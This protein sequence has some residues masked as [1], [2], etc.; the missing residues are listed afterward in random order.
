MNIREYLRGQRLVTDGAMGTYYASLCGKETLVSEW[1]NLTNPELIRQ[2]HREYLEAGATL[3]RTNTFAANQRMLGIGADEQKEMLRAACRIAKEAVAA[4]EEETGKHC[5][6]AGD[7]GPLRVLA[8][9]S[10]AEE[11][12]VEYRSMV[13]CFLEEGVD[14][15]LFETFSD[16]E[17]L[18]ELTEEIRRKNAEVFCMA[19]FSLNQSGYS[20]GGKSAMRLLGQAVKMPGLDAVGFNC[21]VGSGH[22]LRLLQG[23]RLPKE[24]YFCVSPNAGYP[25]QLQNRMVFLKN[26]AYFRENMQQIAGAGVAILGACCGSTPAYIKEL[27]ELVKDL[28]PIELAAEQQRLEGLENGGQ[29]QG[30][31]GRM[32]EQ[33]EMLTAEPSICYEN[34]D[35]FAKLSAGKKVIA[36]ELDPPYDAKDEKLL[37]C[38]KR[39]QELE[40]DLLTVADSPQGRSRMDSI[41]TA[42]KLTHATGL[43]VMPHLS[44]RDRNVIAI[45]SALL[46]AYAND[47]RNVLF[48]TGDPVPGEARGNTTAVFDYNSVNLMNFAQEL[49]R[50]HFAE[51]PFVYGGAI[52]QGRRNFEIE[53]GR[54]KKKVAAGAKFFLTQPVYSEE[55]MLRL[56]RVKE[57]TGA[58]VLAGI[59]PLVSYRNANFVKNEVV[60][61]DVPE[62]VLQRYHPE[63]TREEGE[64]A[65][66]A[67]ACEI[68]EKIKDWTD[69]YYFMLPFNRV[70]LLEQI[71]ASL[72]WL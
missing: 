6:V 15:I 50:E 55:D 12:L 34:N 24:K 38:A 19:E 9:E 5:F 1:A 21:G 17:Y 53:L 65:G 40:V 32:Q 37:A 11:V 41:L 16:T 49:N 29:K 7:I 43:P 2:I 51:E 70:G 67:L 59:M 52:N 63:M 61:I 13:D 47:I 66:V 10:G 69:G 22:M 60:G 26:T 33:E 45:R 8:A 62:E 35:L 57:E 4:Y 28:P 68:I 72:D 44:C 64:A 18:M 56:R 71:K 27:A 20:L 31:A 30:G 42:V 39:L 58:Y 23:L 48:V 25:E 36:V 3:I 14:A 46:G 54:V